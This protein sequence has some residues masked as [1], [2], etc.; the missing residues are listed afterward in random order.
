MTIL[1]AENFDITLKVNKVVVVDFWAEWCQ[2]CKRMSPVFDKASEQYENVVFAK[3]DAD[4]DPDILAK[5]NVQGIP[6][7]IIFNDARPVAEMVG[8]K[9]ESSLI[10]FLELNLSK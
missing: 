6:T 3:V 4:H 10:K 2:P 5:Y 1:T 7:T 9:G 8:F